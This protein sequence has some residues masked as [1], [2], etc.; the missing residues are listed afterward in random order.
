MV[1]FHR[2]YILSSDHY[3]QFIMVNKEK[4]D[5]KTVA[6]YSLDYSKFS[7]HSFRD[8]VSIQSFNVEFDNVNDQFNDFYFKLEGCVDRHAPLI[9]LN[10]KETKLKN[11]ACI[12]NELIKMINVRNK[13]F[14]RKKCQPNN[15]NVTNLYKLFRNRINREIKKSERDFFNQYIENNSNNIKKYGMVLDLSSIQKIQPYQILPN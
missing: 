8:D 9:K 2:F 5:L 14:Q 13:L 7:A 10:S 1:Y 11:K 12:S 4:L 6:V 15:T 3:S